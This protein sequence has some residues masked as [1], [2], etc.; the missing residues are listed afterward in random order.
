[1]MMVDDGRGGG[2]CNMITSSFFFVLNHSISLSEIASLRDTF[3]KKEKFK[4]KIKAIINI[5]KLGHFKM[6]IHEYF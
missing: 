4:L 5:E 2:G 1:M 6:D 3:V